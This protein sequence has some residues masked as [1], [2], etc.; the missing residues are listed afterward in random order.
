MFSVSGRNFYVLR[1]QKFLCSLSVAEVSTFFFDGRS[2]NVL[3]R[4]QK[5]LCL[6]QRPGRK[7]TFSASYIEGTL[8]LSP[9]VKLLKRE[10]HH[11]HFHLLAKSKKVRSHNLI[12]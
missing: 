9:G 12:L 1:W 8:T 6:L 2:F 5:F 11:T 7:S 3:Q 10:P 4:W